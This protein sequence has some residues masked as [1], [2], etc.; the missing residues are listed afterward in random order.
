MS[1]YVKTDRIV[2]RLIFLLFFEGKNH[3]ES[4]RPNHYY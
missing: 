4:I 1:I 3:Y 2:G